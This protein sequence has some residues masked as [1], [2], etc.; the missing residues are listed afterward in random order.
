MTKTEELRNHISKLF[1]ACEDKQ[2][3]SQLG[4]IKNTLDEIDAEAKAKDD[5]YKTLLNDYKDV[6]LHS[7]YK[8][9][10]NVDQTQGTAEFDPDQFIAEFL[11]N[12]K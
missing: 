3:I 7:S 6:V 10:S 2:T 5:E 9:Q 11:A 8:P 1:E 4:V 12:N